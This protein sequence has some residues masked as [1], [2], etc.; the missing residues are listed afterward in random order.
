[1]EK[2]L[3]MNWDMFTHIDGLLY[4]NAMDASQKFLA[5]G[6]PKSCQFTVLFKAHDSLGFTTLLSDNTIGKK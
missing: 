6:I 3:T 2:H 4:K 5:L 1:M